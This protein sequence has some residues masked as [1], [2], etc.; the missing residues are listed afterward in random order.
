MKNIEIT[1]YHPLIQMG[2]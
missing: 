1:L 2:L